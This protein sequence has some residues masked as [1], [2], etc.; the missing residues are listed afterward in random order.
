[1]CKH[2]RKSHRSTNDG[3]QT[4]R[5]C[6][7]IEHTFIKHIC[8]ASPVLDTIFSDDQKKLLRKICILSDI[9]GLSET[10]LMD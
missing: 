8:D 3:S 2:R 6:F 10:K 5:K 1:M 4:P 7:L 9:V